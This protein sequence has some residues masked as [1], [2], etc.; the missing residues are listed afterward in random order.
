[1]VYPLGG[2][3]LSM[4]SDQKS[5]II[6][7][8]FGISKSKF[9]NHVKAPSVLGALVCVGTLG[10]EELAVS[11]LRC[12]SIVLHPSSTRYQVSSI[13][14]HQSSIVYYPVPGIK[15][16]VLCYT[17]P[18]SCYMIHVLSHNYVPV[19]CLYLVIG[20]PIYN[21]IQLNGELF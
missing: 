2:T 16:P 9:T 13:V 11:Q 8:L 18:V 5:K 1:M 14:L 12:Q 4:N 17:T 6:Q 3:E 20:I 7:K 21:T 15:Y 10:M 19:I